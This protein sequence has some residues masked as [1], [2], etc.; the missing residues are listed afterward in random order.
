MQ[1][2]LVAAG[3]VVVMREDG[4][5]FHEHAEVTDDRGRTVFAIPGET[6]GPELGLHAEFVA[7]GTYQLWGQF[8]RA[9][10]EVLAVPFTDDAKLRG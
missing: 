1:P 2:F 5:T 6:F 7:P 4:Q 3:H 8:R 10:G 9:D